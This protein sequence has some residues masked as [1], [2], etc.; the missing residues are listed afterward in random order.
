MEST[1]LGRSREDYLEAILVQT[2][3]NGACRA[4]DI[5][6]GLGFSRPSVSIALQKLEDEG[7]I[8]SG[9]SPEK[10]DSEACQIE[11]AVSEDSFLR[12]RNYVRENLTAGVHPDQTA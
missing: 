3:R 8:R 12:L 4:V 10:A 7:L 6:T 2:R 9:V 1:A 11:H 5:A